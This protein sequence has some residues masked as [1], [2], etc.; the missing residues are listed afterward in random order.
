M[1]GF[2]CLFTHK[3]ASFLYHFYMKLYLLHLYTTFPPSSGR[4]TLSLLSFCPQNHLVRE[5]WEIVIGPTLPGNFKGKQRFGT[6]IKWVSW[7]QFATYP[8]WTGE[9]PSISV[10]AG[11]LISLT[12][13]NTY[14]KHD[15]KYENY[16][17]TPTLLT[18]LYN[19]NGW[20]AENN[21]K[22]TV[23][24]NQHQPMY[25][26]A[27]ELMIIASIKQQTSCPGTSVSMKAHNSE[28]F[29]SIIVRGLKYDSHPCSLK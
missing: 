26:V 29:F 8:V 2:Y 25:C 27:L 9:V 13:N 14:S 4:C 3:T 19:N 17:G 10:Y 20:K 12:C 28:T 24:G 18:T 7:N 6:W 15:V 1:W 21:N 23:V 16:F 5:V 22:N 11:L